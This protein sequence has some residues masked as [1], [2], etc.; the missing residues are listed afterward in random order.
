LCEREVPPNV[1]VADGHTIKCHLP[2]G[3]LKEMEPV[4]S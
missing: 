2:V 1:A 4:F 3:T